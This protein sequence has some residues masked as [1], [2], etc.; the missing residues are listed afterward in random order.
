MA[1]LAVF[2]IDGTLCD[3]NSV[4]DACFVQAVAELIGL[5]ASQ[6]D[7]SDAPHIT[8]SGLLDWLCAKHRFRP[9]EPSDLDRVL[10]RFIELLHERAAASPHLFRAIPGAPEA[11]ASLADVDWDIALATGGWRHSAQFKLSQ[12]GVDADA[13]VLATANDAMK[14]ADI[15]QVAVHQAE[16]RLRMPY[17]RVVSLGDGPWDVST[18]IELGIPFV[19]IGSGERASRLRQAGAG[20]VLENM[21]DLSAFHA[22]LDTA[23]VPAR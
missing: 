18:A 13:F 14:R 10:G 12:I 8:D 2:D 1:C 3:T 11:L 7:W 21:L 9:L 5:E 23:R 15:V 22:A 6:I 17:T 16:T 19:G 20:I 4:D